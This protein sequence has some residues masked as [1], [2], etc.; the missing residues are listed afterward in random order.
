MLANLY[1]EQMRVGAVPAEREAERQRLLQLAESDE[2]RNYL[3][4]VTET[5][6]FTS[7][8]LRRL[9]AVLVAAIVAA[10]AI[11]LATSSEAQAAGTKVVA[12]P[13]PN[14]SDIQIPEL[15]QA[16]PYPSELKVSGFKRGRIRD[17]N[18]YLYGFD[19]TYP[20]D[21][22]MMLVGPTG[23]QA[24]VMSD[25]GGGFDVIGKTVILDD[26]HADPLPDDSD[27]GS[28][29]VNYWKPANYGV[30]LD[31]FP[32]PAP[33]SSGNSALSVF[34]G[35]RPNGTWR[36]YIV[37]DG[38]SDGGQFSGGWLLTITARVGG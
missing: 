24:I 15:G 33:A 6:H 13:F 2:E 30:T 5:N 37:D 4:M 22:D 17:V 36:L 31:T 14:Y 1:T 8:N 9:V 21:M 18:L 7:T 16:T 26:E 28:N 23:K 35:S 10:L 3:E 27:L 19:H 29:G 25:A 11:S 38:I 12:M 32:S 20:D 34:D